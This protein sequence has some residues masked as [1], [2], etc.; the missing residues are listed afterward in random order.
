MFFEFD[1]GK[2]LCQTG[3]IEG[4]EI[5]H[6]QNI[7]QTADMIFVAVR[8]EDTANVLLFVAQIARIGNNKIDAE[9]LLV[10]EHYSGIDN[11]DVVTILYDHHILSD[12]PQASQWDQSNFFCCQGI[13]NLLTTPLYVAL[14]KV[15]Y[16]LSLSISTSVF[17]YRSKSHQYY[18]SDRL[19]EAHT[20][21]L[22]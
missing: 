16:V 5:E 7:R 20:L 12:F 21:H 1:V 14:L 8:N 19:S 22:C 18:L 10:G 3:R 9:H 2:A 6:W 4:R 15:L 17:V 13:R 11:D